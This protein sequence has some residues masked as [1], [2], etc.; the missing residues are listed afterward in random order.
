MDA[1]MAP[2]RG[3]V[4]FCVDVVI[5]ARTFEAHAGEPKIGELRKRRDV[6][7]DGAAEL[8]VAEVELLK[9]RRE[10]RE[11]PQRLG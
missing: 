8:V 3:L 10:R 4:S 2:A 6:F 1:G 11:Q 9:V 7:R 5:Q